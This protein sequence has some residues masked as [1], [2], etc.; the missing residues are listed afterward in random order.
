METYKT[1]IYK[2]IEIKIMYD[3]DYESPNEWGDDE[4]FLVYDHRELEIKVKGFNPDDIFETMMNKR[5]TFAGYYYFPVFAY[6]HGGVSLSL[7]KNSY[8]FTCPWDTSFKGFSLV[9]REKGRYT[10]DKAYKEAENLISTWNQCLSGEVFGYTSEYGSCWG[11]YGRESIPYMISV[12]KGEIDQAEK[13]QIRKHGRKVKTW[14]KNHVPLTKRES[15]Q[16]A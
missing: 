10:R 12:A 9:K 6:I 4:V 7:S 15:Y 14:I 8:P 16:L 13:E 5:K 11:Y 1:E 3:E 2:G